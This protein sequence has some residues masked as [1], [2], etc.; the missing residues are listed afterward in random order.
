[1][2]EVVAD[3]R[4]S[5]GVLPLVQTT[6]LE[7]WVRRDGDLLA[8]D[9]YRA[10]GGVQGAVARLA[11][12]TYGSLSEPQQR[13]AWRILLRLADAS[14]NGALDLRRRVPI[15]EVFVPATTAPRLRSSN[16]WRIGWSSSTATRSRSRTRRC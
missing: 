6:L 15:T 11:E 12:S 9:T 5:T 1:M 3:A 2:D 10:A 14:D 8:L 13:A 16:W 4:G 7:T